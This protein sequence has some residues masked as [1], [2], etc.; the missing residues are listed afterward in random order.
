[1]KLLTLM[2]LLLLAPGLACAAFT[3]NGDGTITDTVT[4]LQWQKATMDTNNDGT[5][6]QSTWQQALAAA[7]GLTLAGNSDWRLPDR[8]ELYSLVDY[9]RNNPAIDPVFAA[10]TQPSR[11]WSS[12]T[13]A[14][15]SGDAW[16]VRFDYGVDDYGN[17]GNSY[18]AR[19]VRGGQ[20]GA[21][22]YL[23]NQERPP[24]P[25]IPPDVSGT[26]RNAVVLTHGWRSDAHA[27][28][29]SMSSKICNSLNGTVVDPVGNDLTHTCKAGAWD[30]FVYDWSTMAGTLAPWSA[31]ANAVERGTALGMELAKKNYAHV[32]LLAHSAGSML[33]ESAKEYLRRLPQKPFIHLTFFDAYD[34][35]AQIKD[36]VQLSAYGEGSD[37]A[38]NYVDTRTLDTLFANQMDGTKQL[39][40]H[41]YNVDVSKW[42]NRQQPLPPA[43]ILF[44]HEWPYVFYD[45]YTFTS[46]DYELGYQLSK[47]EGLTPYPNPQRGKKTVCSLPSQSGGAVLACESVRSVPDL[48]T[49]PDRIRTIGDPS[50]VIQ[51]VTNSVTG[52]IN[53]FQNPVT[54]IISYWFF[55]T[56]SPVWSGLQL[57][58]TEP[59]NTLQFDYEFLS[60][61]GAE[62][63]VTIFVD[64]Q[65]VGRLDERHEVS[66]GVHT[67]RR[68]YIGELAPGIHRVAVRIDPCT[69]EQSTLRLTNLKLSQTERDD[70]FPWHL[71]LPA[72]I[73]GSKYPN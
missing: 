70:D 31:W 49:R 50:A 44:R 55:Q 19:A 24:D 54:G 65:V 41:A 13:D 42:D 17:K 62:G 40:P 48:E 58:T 51:Q 30:V 63:Y 14:N 8:N 7:E 53:L 38:D 39:M 43:A 15:Y 68:M 64:E 47:E 60:T 22:S 69:E 6:D 1:M 57:K 33:I 59:F 61:T 3:D 23:I 11:Y 4:C 71:F 10:T 21:S 28:A 66:T 72:L 26:G 73:G 5:P 18:Y 9:S 2:L 46:M 16:L 52:V 35:F 67:S 56:G 37:W 36:G 45:S 12:T 27:W 25:V 20:C 32:H 29:E 34:P